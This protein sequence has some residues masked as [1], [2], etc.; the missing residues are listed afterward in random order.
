MVRDW[1]RKRR[2]WIRDK[3]DL[4]D[5]SRQLNWKNVLIWTIR[6]IK[7]SRL[8]KVTSNYYLERLYEQQIH[9]SII[10]RTHQFISHLFKMILIIWLFLYI[11]IFSLSLLSEFL[12]YING[13]RHES[14]WLTWEYRSVW[15]LHFV[16]FLKIWTIYLVHPT[17]CFRYFQK[18]GDPSH[19]F[20]KVKYF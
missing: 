8:V 4:E 20:S 11:F 14:T 19:N 1:R 16:C 7:V 17:L 18:T 5:N 2:I 15:G 9:E 10:G 12:L 13:L 3:Q 6:D